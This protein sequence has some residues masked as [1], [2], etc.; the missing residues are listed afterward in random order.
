MSTVTVVHKKDKICMACESL[1]TF[2]TIKLNADNQ[3][4]STKI[5]QWGDSLVG[6][7]G[8]VSIEMILR[9]LIENGP[10]DPDF[11]SSMAVFRYFKS[12]HPTLKADYFINT[13]EDEDDPVES[14]QFEIVLA[15]QHGIFGV[16]SMRDIYQFKKFWAYGS[17][18]RYAMGAMNAVYDLDNFDAEQIAK[19]GVQAG[20]TFD[21]ASGGPIE[22]K[23]ITIPPKSLA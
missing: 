23:S 7:V 16:H 8:E 13:K 17:G 5:Y 15:N 6:F 1:V 14:S 20:I 22:C 18:R 21:D 3:L 11:S 2:G 10:K 9:D 19:A 12:I 4:D